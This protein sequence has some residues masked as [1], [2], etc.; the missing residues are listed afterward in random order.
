M[1]IR[2]QEEKCLSMV[3]ILLNMKCEMLDLTK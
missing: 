2:I 1:L 3:T